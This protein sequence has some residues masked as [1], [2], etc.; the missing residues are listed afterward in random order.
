MAL[1]N[2]VKET[3]LEAEGVLRNALYKAAKNERPSTLMAIS[4][5]IGEIG[6]LESFDS[7][8]DLIEDNLDDIKKR[9]SE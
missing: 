2:D 5:I 9:D 8:Q 6:K 7:I 1:T 3:L 4:R